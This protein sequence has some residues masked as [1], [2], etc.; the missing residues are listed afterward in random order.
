MEAEPPAAIFSSEF[1]VKSES[2]P[3]LYFWVKVWVWSVKSRQILVHDKSTPFKQT[4][5][6]PE[7]A[8]IFNWS[9][10]SGM[11]IV[12]LG[13]RCGTLWFFNLPLKKK[14]HFQPQI[15][16]IWPIF[17]N[18]SE[19][20]PKVFYIKQKTSE[21]LSKLRNSE[22]GG[23]SGYLFSC[24]AGGLINKKTIYFHH[25]F[26]APLFY[27]ISMTSFSSMGSPVEIQSQPTF[28]NWAQNTKK[29]NEKWQTTTDNNQQ[30]TNNYKQLQM[31]NIKQQ[32]TKA[33]VHSD[34]PKTKDPKLKILESWGIIPVLKIRFGPPNADFCLVLPKSA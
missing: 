18:D 14:T 23:G 15:W 8:Y 17:P 29:N 24:P 5:D 28:T 2:T 31:A 4:L 25:V 21:I 22:S 6:F 11:N 20:L 30:T 3:L 32:T 26:I 9:L 19:S 12:E 16:S 13:C 1:W 34:G 33:N 27:L 10:S 7:N